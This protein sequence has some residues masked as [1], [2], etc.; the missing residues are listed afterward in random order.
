[1]GRYKVRA[2]S[3][4]VGC[5]RKKRIIKIRG[6]I[7]NKKTFLIPIMLV[8]IS[9][10]SLFAADYKTPHR[11][12]DGDVVSA[13][14]LNEI[15]DYIEAS[16]K[17][18]LPQDLVG[19][20][21]CTKYRVLYDNNKSLPGTSI[22][23]SNLIRYVNNLKLIITAAANGSYIWSSPSRN[24]FSSMFA[25]LDGYSNPTGRYSDECTGNG[26]MDSME[27]DLFVS[28]PNCLNDLSGYGSGQ[29]PT[30]Q[31]QINL[32]KISSSRV[33]IH[34]DNINLMCDIQK[35]PPAI[36]TDLKVSVI[37][38]VVKLTWID[39]SSDEFVFTLL[40]KDSDGDWAE[41]GTV[42]ANTTS[43][44]EPLKTGVHSY[45]VKSRNDVGDSLGSN[46]VVV[47][48]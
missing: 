9:F 48:K 24:I 35:M 29:Y 17:T 5:D 18:V 44:S 41:V 21:N 37:N 26:V 40:R 6:M 10:T 7:M 11:F 2:L 1:V 4:S 12:K 47:D 46:V 39:N 30:Y 42:P 16:K 27:G 19:E 22:S 23:N 31:L 32:N 33:Q 25:V 45:R 34:F 13:D 3:G 43:F 20:W 15:F 28:S 8:F 36:P 38:D 14:V